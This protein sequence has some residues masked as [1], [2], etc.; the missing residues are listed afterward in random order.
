MNGRFP[1][2]GIH[3]F[4]CR[5]QEQGFVFPGESHPMPELI[6]VE[7]G[8]LHCVAEG[9]EVLL[10][11]GELTFFGG[12]RWHMLYADIGMAPR[13]ASVIFEP[14][15]LD[16]SPLLN[17]KFTASSQVKNALQ[18][19]I[20][21]QAQPDAYAEGMQ[22]S[23]LCLALVQL[24]REQKTA[25]GE[26]I[27]AP[28]GENEIIRLAQQYVSTHVREKLSVP[29]VA[30]QVDVSPS[31]LT[32]LFHKHLD[33]SPG[34]YVRRVK[35]QE[36]KRMIREEKMNFTEIAAA[37]QYSTVHHYSRQFKEKFG[38]TPS[39]YAKSVR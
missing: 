3:S 15:K 14:V 23:Q 29:Q 34:E 28:N 13:Y 39:E 22:L 33:I 30:E 11:A 35:L 1:I 16:I 4:L 21:E 36:S 25:P 20:L 6:Y 37:L 32:A 17:R 27:A 24:L 10:H 7:Q 5:E 12:D 2:A 26:R 8:T 9:R 38:I 19:M 18:Q 31:Y